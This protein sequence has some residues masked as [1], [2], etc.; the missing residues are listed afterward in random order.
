L[1][2]LLVACSSS[3]K[4]PAAGA[5][6]STTKDASSVDASTSTDGS[7]GDAADDG[8]S[9]DAADGSLPAEAFVL[10]QVSPSATTSCPFSS[11]TDWL[12]VGVPLASHP[13]TIVNGG[14][15]NGATVHVV[16]SVV[17][18]G[19]D[20]DIALSISKD[21]AGGS[22]LVITS[23]AGQGAVSDA[24][25]KGVRVD[26]TSPTLPTATQTSCTLR[27]T[28]GAGPVPSEAPVAPGTIWAH[29]SCPNTVF[30]S[31]AATPPSC[32]GEADFFFENCVAQ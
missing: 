28:Y 16:C 31:D 6:A 9:S 30:A 10:S 1:A 22:G 23:P 20:F 15:E 17:P 27:F 4:G 5:D 29:V 8:S 18:V 19:D 26:W 32:D 25:A 13:L 12:D 11:V 2:A 24:G 21:G 7:G 14:S 3:S